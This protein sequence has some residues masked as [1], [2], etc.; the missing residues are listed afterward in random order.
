MQLRKPIKQNKI[1][2]QPITI[3]LPPFGGTNPRP[4][5]ARYRKYHPNHKKSER[6]V[7]REK[8]IRG[9]KF[10][11]SAVENINHIFAF[12]QVAIAIAIAL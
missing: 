5:G 12:T 9:I 11:K 6:R 10:T 3:P 4:C 8:M 1:A 2:P 7:K